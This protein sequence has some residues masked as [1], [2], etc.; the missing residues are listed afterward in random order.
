MRRVLT[1]EDWWRLLRQ[2]AVEVARP[3]TWERCAAD[4]LAVYRALT[5]P[6][7]PV[8]RVAA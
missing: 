8:R 1:D 6:A 4:T 3:F 2:G 7:E 5:A